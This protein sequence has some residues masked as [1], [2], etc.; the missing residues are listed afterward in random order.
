MAEIQIPM[1]KAILNWKQGDHSQIV[2][3]RL[4]EILWYENGGV[5]CHIWFSMA[6]LQG[7]VLF[8]WC[9][10]VSFPDG[11][12]TQLCPMENIG[13]AQES[14]LSWLHSRTSIPF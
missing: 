12:S 13:E 7:I 10:R 6:H 14:C 8:G 5:L 4:K 1:A 3:S 11:E 9:W 2:V